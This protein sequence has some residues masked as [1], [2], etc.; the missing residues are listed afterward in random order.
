MLP[1]SSTVIRSLFAKKRKEKELETQN[2]SNLKLNTVKTLSAGQVSHKVTCKLTLA[3]S[4]EGASSS[5]SWE[6]SVEHIIN[7]NS[8]CI[9]VVFKGQ[10]SH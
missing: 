7:V 9:W 5:V 10:V 6:T 8:T 4:A 2:I 1:Y 3:L